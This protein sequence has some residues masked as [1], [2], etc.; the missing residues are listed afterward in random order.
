MS[1][2]LLLVYF[3][4]IAL[5]NSFGIC[6]PQDDVQSVPLSPNKNWDA[7]F[8]EMLAG[9]GI[10]FVHENGARGERYVVEPMSSGI[11]LFD[12]DGDG[13]IDIYFVNGSIL[14]PSPNQIDAS[15]VKPKNRL[16][17]NQGNWRFADVTDSAG[18]GDVIYGLGAVAGDY[19]NE[20]DM[21]LY[22][23]NFGPIV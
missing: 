21:D 7:Q 11:A 9:S 18:V 16:Y 1:I 20:G 17:R 19:D 22:V 6:L 8:V 12:F 5:M 3:A 23:S 14:N 2:Y 10:D 4:F 15:E 13:L